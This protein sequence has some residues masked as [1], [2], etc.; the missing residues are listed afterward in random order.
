MPETK[1][2]K[3]ILD[4]D[5]LC[6]YCKSEA[7]VQHT[8]TDWEKSKATL[9]QLLDKIRGKNKFDGL[10]ML[11]GGKDS[12]YS[13]YLLTKVYKLKLLALTIDNGF[14]YNET[15]DNAVTAARKLNMPLITYTL[16]YETMKDYYRFLI[17]D[18][19]I[20]RDDATQICF[21][22]GRYFKQIAMDIARG[23]GITTIFSGHNP[24]QL[25]GMGE[26]VPTQKVDSVKERYLKAHTKRAYANAIK[27][28]RKDGRDELVTLFKNE[29]DDTTAITSIYPLEYFEYSPFKMIATIEE[30]LNWKPIK[31]FSKMYIASGCKMAKIIQY[32]AYSN[33]TITYV[34]REFHD[35]IRQGILSK[36]ALQEFYRTLDLEGEDVKN[37]LKELDI[38]EPLEEVCKTKD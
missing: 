17:T 19:S 7:K 25:E 37:I 28:C 24:Q 6:I 8:E 16:A 12:V 1:G 31:R 22:C 27:S 3:K 5:G 13:A 32:A 36:E 38:N 9:E 21:F 34:D 11:S 10:I 23:F 2:N 15:F 14:E 33:G 26:V 35:Q 4:E 18:K 20:K 30:N 29:L